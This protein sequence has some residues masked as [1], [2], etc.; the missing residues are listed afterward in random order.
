MNNYLTKRPI[1]IHVSKKLNLD[2]DDLCKLLK[3]ADKQIEKAVGTIKRRGL[4]END[5][6][7]VEFVYKK[8]TRVEIKFRST[9]LRIEVEPWKGL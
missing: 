2:I 6:N 9:Y 8:E 4:E 1:E 3:I 5:L 7:N